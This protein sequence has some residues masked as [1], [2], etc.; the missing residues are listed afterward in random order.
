MTEPCQQ[1]SELASAYLDNELS[2]TESLAI[3]RHLREC[4]NCSREVS[5]LAGLSGQIKTH[6]RYHAASTALIDR[7]RTVSAPAASRQPPSKFLKPSSFTGWRPM[8]SVAAVA[9]LLAGV[10]MWQFAGRNAETRLSNEILSS[11]I[12][13]TLSQQ[14]FDVASSDRHTV[15][16]WFHG[17]LNFAPPVIDLSAQNYVLQGGRLDFVDGRTV[18][19]IGYGR[20]KH[21]INLYIWPNPGHANRLPKQTNVNGYNL[22]YWQRDGLRLAAISDLA[23]GELAE[24][25]RQFLSQ[26]ASEAPNS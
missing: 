17:K 9:I 11:H 3:E 18:P 24:F 20:R 14:P 4:A 1:T 26:S 19:V 12:R 23:A 5:V 15:K 6:A 10:A 2:A 25:A 16:P 21:V 7:V 8:V 13:S 22:I